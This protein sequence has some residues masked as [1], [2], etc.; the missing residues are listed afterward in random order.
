MIPAP[1]YTPTDL[2]LYLH[3]LKTVEPLSCFGFDKPH[4][5]FDGS[6]QPLDPELFHRACF[7]AAHAVPM[8]ISSLTNKHI[9]T[10][11]ISGR[12]QEAIAYRNRFYRENLKAVGRVQ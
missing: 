4:I 7:E 1:R 11:E 3:V 8:T 5:P 10:R 6:I 12:L 2:S 9:A